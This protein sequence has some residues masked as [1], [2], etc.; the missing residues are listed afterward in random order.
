M[1]DMQTF[2][3]FI[4]E[5]YDPNEIEALLNENVDQNMIDEALA[6]FIK[7]ANEEGYTIQ[8]LQ[9]ELANEG[10]IGSILGGLT[11]FALGQ[12]VGRM[13]ANAL[14]VEK[15]LLFD[16]MTSRVIGAAIGYHLG[17]RI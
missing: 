5:A 10:F 17:K 13:V 15:G 9:E 14:G 7:K 3:E 16:L 6:A 1:K 2:N 11:G 8:Q 4:G 12:A